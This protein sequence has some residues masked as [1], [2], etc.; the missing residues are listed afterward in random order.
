MSN[1]NKQE[2]FS[3]L[4]RMSNSDFSKGRV[5]EFVSMIREIETKFNLGCKEMYNLYAEMIR[6]KMELLEIDDEGI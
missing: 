2:V 5:Y 4:T 6:I 3:E 1:E